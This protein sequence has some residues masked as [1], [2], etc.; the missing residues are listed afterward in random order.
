[1]DPHQARMGFAQS[2]DNSLIPGKLL[3]HVQHI[4]L[5]VFINIILSMLDFKNELG[6][7]FELCMELVKEKKD[8][9]E[10]H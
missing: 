1:M 2:V 9:T 3:L 6:L 5:K 8:H 10:T 4:F 7:S